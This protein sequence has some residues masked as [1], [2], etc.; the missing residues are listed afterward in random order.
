[1]NRHREGAAV[2][3]AKKHVFSVREAGTSAHNLVLIGDQ[4]QLGQPT[5]G[6]HPGESGLSALDYALLDHATVPP[7]L[8]IFLDR[9][10]RMHPDI[11]CFV[12]DTFYEGRLRPDPAN[13]QQRLM[14][15]RQA[16]A[17]LSPTGLPTMLSLLRDTILE[18]CECVLQQ[19]ARAGCGCGIE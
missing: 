1:M 16:D 4:M 19:V 15:G 10:R 7:K 18:A 2:M 12:S 8:G 17:I 13:V 9:T 11:C 14:I 5:Q 3:A 6:V